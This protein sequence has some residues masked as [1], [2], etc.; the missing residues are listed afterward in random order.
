M[1]TYAGA[2]EAS[3]RLRN[4]Y[5][6]LKYFHVSNYICIKWQVKIYHIYITCGMALL[7]INDILPTV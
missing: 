4:I 1:Y 2:S 3:E 6:G 5:I 7:F